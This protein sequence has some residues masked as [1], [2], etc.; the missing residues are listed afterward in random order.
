MFFIEKKL[1]KNSFFL[2]FKAYN[3]QICIL[4]NLMASIRKE[5]KMNGMTDNQFQV[6]FNMIIQILQDNAVDES[7]IKKI[8]ALLE[9]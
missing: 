2:L 4:Y 8:E 9:K 1:L 3:I 5:Y 7:I 6:L